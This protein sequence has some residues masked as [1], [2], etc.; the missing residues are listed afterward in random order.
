MEM[1]YH[2]WASQNFLI[3]FLCFHKVDQITLNLVESSAFEV[4]INSILD[5]IP[6][7]ASAQFMKIRCPRGFGRCPNRHPKDNGRP[8]DDDYFLMIVSDG[9]PFPSSTIVSD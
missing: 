5:D 3:T 7:R 2:T 6:Q 9:F 1:S 4:A 8:I